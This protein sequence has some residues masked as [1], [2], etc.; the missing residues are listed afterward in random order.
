MGCSFWAAH[1][2]HMWKRKS[3]KT[4]EISGFLRWNGE[5][6]HHLSLLSNL[7]SWEQQ[8]PPPITWPLFIHFVWSSRCRSD[9]TGGGWRALPALPL[10]PPPAA[11]AATVAKTVGRVRWSRTPALNNDHREDL[12]PKLGYYSRIRHSAKMVA[13]LR[14]FQA[15]PGEIQTRIPIRAEKS[16]VSFAKHLVTKNKTFKVI[17]KSTSIL[18]RN[19]LMGLFKSV[20]HVWVR[21]NWIASS[22]LR[23][24]LPEVTEAFWL[25]AG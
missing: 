8:G 19:A 13:S 25:F 17:S 16:D 1:F 11:A 6:C 3:N 4:N 12:G 2:D 15:R 14:S 20:C 21:R 22:I 24:N 18:A 5:F 9:V 10:S 7:N 23:F